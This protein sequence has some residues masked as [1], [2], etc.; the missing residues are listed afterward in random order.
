MNW[1]ASP[2]GQKYQSVCTFICFPWARAIWRKKRKKNSS[3]VRACPV[4]PYTT[5]A[6][7]AN[8]ATIKADQW[9]QVSPIRINK[10]NTLKVFLC[11]KAHFI[12]SI[13]STQ[14]SWIGELFTPLLWGIIQHLNPRCIAK[15]MFSGGVA[16][17]IYLTAL[18]V[19]H[20]RTFLGTSSTQG[21]WSHTRI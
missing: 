21:R 8:Y 14:S 18:A 2:Q 6:K 9:D 5:P 11:F 17:R 12:I 10:A 13:V 20:F 16:G 4:P 3:L 19:K 15:Q 1:T 7:S